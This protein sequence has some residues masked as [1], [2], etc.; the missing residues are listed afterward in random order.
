MASLVV[1]VRTAPYG[2]LEAA[3]GVRHLG[4]HSVLGFEQTAGVFCDD[5]VWALRAGQQSAGGFTSL[6]APLG[7]VAAGGVTLYAERASLERR[8][9]QASDLID[10]VSVLDSVEEL[11][12]DADTLLVF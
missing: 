6:A 1:L 2:H 12:A 5:G 3:E 11:L 9:L 8:D 4:A 7:E 10:G